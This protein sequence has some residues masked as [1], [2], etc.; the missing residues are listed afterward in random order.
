MKE[1]LPNF[2]AGGNRRWHERCNDDV[3]RV[4][5]EGLMVK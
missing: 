3:V 5:H 2:G 4:G 1:C